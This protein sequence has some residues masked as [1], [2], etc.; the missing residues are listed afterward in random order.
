MNQN[1]KLKKA[2]LL[3]LLFL[4][5]TGCIKDEEDVV[6]NETS[7]APYSTNGRPNNKLGCI[8]INTRTVNIQAWDHGTI[9]GDIISL[10]ANDD[11]ILDTYE[12]DGPT[13][14]VSVDY[15]FG[16][17]GYNYL[18][19]YAHNEGDISPNTAA[20]S[21]NG[22]EFTLES[23]LSTNGYVDIVVTGYDVTCDAG[24]TGGTD[25]NSLTFYVVDDFGCGPI[26]VTLD[27]YG[28]QTINNYYSSG[29]SGCDVSGCANFN[30]LPEGTYSYEASCDGYTWSNT[31]T[32][33]SGCNKLKLI[34]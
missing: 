21:I 13:N 22:Q 31:I 8:E 7:I 1:V 19:L 33:E 23:N 27:G 17:N 4:L 2:V 10:I 20:I 11:V 29:I 14:K 26:N 32:V 28:T 34:I 30:N 25:D 24:S 12:L 9:D 16:Y 6:V 15:T 5:F 18:V 3:P